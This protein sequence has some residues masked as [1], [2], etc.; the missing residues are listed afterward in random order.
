MILKTIIIRVAVHLLE[1]FFNSLFSIGAA[2]PKEF[3]LPE[4]VR[5][6]IERFGREGNEEIEVM[7]EPIEDGKGNLSSLTIKITT[8]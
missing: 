5:N 1:R 3:Q 4:E 2:P 8:C 6:M 7:L